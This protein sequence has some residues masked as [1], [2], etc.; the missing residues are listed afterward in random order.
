MDPNTLWQDI[1][2]TMKVMRDTVANEGSVPH[3]DRMNDDSDTAAQE[4]WFAACEFQEATK[5]LSDWIDK[6]GVPPTEY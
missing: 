4:Y 1:L 2:H 5:A 6:G 3:T